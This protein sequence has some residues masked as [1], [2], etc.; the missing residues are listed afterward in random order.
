MNRI[1]LQPDEWQVVPADESEHTLRRL[2]I[3]GTVIVAVAFGGLGGWLVLA[4]LDSAAVA[5]GS[6][7]VDSHRKTVQHLEGG[8]VRR[9]HVKDGDP[10][11]A[12]QVLIEL[13]GSQAQ[14][15]LGQARNQYWTA[16]ARVARLEAEQHGADSLAWPEDL[17]MNP[18]LGRILDAQADLFRTRRDSRRALLAVREKRIGQMM[19][20]V[21]GLEAQ[22]QASRETLALN[23]DELVSVEKM[24]Q[25]GYE[26]KPR[27]LQLQRTSAELKGA[28]GEATAKI[29]RAEQEMS[30]AELEVI[31]LRNQQAQEIAT[32]LD[33]ARTQLSDLADRLKAAEDI[34]ARTHIRAPQDGRVVDLKV[35][36][37]GGVVTPG[38]PLLDIVPQNDPLLI[39]AQV[40]PGDI[41][42]VHPGLPASIRLTAYSQRRTPPVEGTVVHVSADKL[43]DPRTGEPYFTARIKP[44][45]EALAALDEVALTPGMPAEVYITTGTRRAIDYLISPF[46]DSMRRAF[47]EQ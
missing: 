18:T 29:A 40:R 19:Q 47:R 2:M 8:I 41:D 23:A 10:V 11:T 33:E 28:I 36:T 3:A 32:E 6:V 7:V 39:E 42:V 25:Q 15:A 45:A 9:L 14:A 13:E 21:I 30:Q 4:P 44:S 46:T 20:E 27:L 43:V 37:V 17:A 34:I 22:R 5:H 12:G 35:F 31:T 26:R 1:D 24:V 38:M 16:R